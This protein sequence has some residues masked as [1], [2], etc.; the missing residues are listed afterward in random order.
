MS[1]IAELATHMKRIE[2]I[3]KH[4]ARWKHEP[5]N[6]KI[7]LANILI[8]QP[9]QYRSSDL[10]RHIGFVAGEEDRVL[11]IVRETM[12][13][14]MLIKRAASIRTLSAELESLRAILPGLAARA[15]I[16]LGVTARA[17]VAELE[18]ED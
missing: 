9:S 14:D 2:E 16:E 5:S 10:T 13:A 15:S 8:A 12:Q 1:A 17:M 3:E 18:K 11:G 7:R 6:L 4:F